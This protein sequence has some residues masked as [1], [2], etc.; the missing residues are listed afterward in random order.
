MKIIDKHFQLDYLNKYASQMVIGNGQLGIRGCHEEDYENQTRGLLINGIYNSPVG[1]TISEL[2]NLPDVIKLHLKIDG[3][4]ISPFQ[5]EIIHYERYLDTNTG[6]LVRHVEFRLA[7]GKEITY[8]TSRF[9]SQTDNTIAQKIK[10]YSKKNPIAVEVISGIDAQITNNG[11]QHLL[12]QEIRVFDS[13]RIE[14]HYETIE[15]R[16]TIRYH[17]NFNKK[18]VFQSKNRQVYASFKENLASEQIFELEKITSIQ[19][20]LDFSPGIVHKESYECLK[21]GAINY[22]SKFWQD[23]RIIIEGDSSAQNAL[24]FALYHLNIMTPRSDCRFSIGAKGLT[25]LG[26]KGHVFWDTEIFILPYFLH[27][28]P[29][30]AK[31]LLKYRHQRLNGA[32]KK[33]KKYGFSGAMFPWES[34][35]SGKEE[36]PEYAAIN[37]RTGLRQKIAS[38]EAEHHIVADIAFAVE[39]YFMSTG[40]QVFMKKYGYQLI[41]ETAE[42]W[43]SR[44]TDCQNRL[45]IHRVIGPDEYTEYIDNNAYTNYLA[46]FNV[47]LAKKYHLGSSEFQ[48]KCQ[49]FLDNLYLPKVNCDGI[50]PQ[51]DSFLTKKVIDLSSYKKCQGTQAILLDYSR[52]EVNE[53]QILKQAD[54]IMLMYLFPDYFDKDLVKKNFDYYESRTIHDSSLSKSIHAIEALRTDNIDLG[55]DLFK[56]ACLIDLGS[57]PHSSDDGLHAAALASLWHVIVFGFIGITKGEL[58]SINPKLPSHWSSVTFPFTWKEKK[59]QITVTQESI[60]ISSESLEET[61]IYINSKKYLLKNKLQLSY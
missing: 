35:Y 13:N 44:A 10:I 21:S 28:N 24:D 12:E 20:S 41:L 48:E 30:I 47:Q 16:Q 50:L 42:F 6:E 25:G 4:Y 60:T 59:L 9:V 57:D 46:Y 19:T 31:N 8:L 15:S 45:E 2:V 53:M 18:G 36:T 51:D 58:I 38:G 52:Q 11:S 55:F 1:S 56:E 37:I 14:A 61:D 22:W 7:S 54:V 29:D 26:Y 34:A 32:Q 40:D 23:Q 39:D 5:Q 3:E 17:V 49:Y 43:L 27:T 33:A